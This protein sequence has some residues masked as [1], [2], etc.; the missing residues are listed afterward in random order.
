MRSGSFAHRVLIAVGLLVVLTLLFTAAYV[1]LFGLSLRL[2][3]Q[4]NMLRLLTFIKR[5]NKEL[6]LRSW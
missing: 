6:I 4:E 2:W 5:M 1:G 3:L